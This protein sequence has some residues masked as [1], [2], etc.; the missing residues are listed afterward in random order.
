MQQSVNLDIVEPF[1]LPS[2]AALLHLEFAIGHLDIPLLLLEL[3]LFLVLTEF[4]LYFTNNFFLP[5]V[6][7]S[8]SVEFDY[9]GA[10][11]TIGQT[12]SV[13]EAFIFF[14]SVFVLLL[15]LIHNLVA[16][17]FNSSIVLSS[18]SWLHSRLTQMSSTS[19]S[20][21]AKRGVN[22]LILLVHV[23]P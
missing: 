19:H 2:S 5:L 6:P 18:S 21:L 12:V 23:R 11:N 14:S 16:E 17:H 7:F 4:I 20:L 8:Y 3:V 9:G 15:S 10:D 13:E 1:L 22:N